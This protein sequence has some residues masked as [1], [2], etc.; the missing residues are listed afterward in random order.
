MLLLSARDEPTIRHIID[1]RLTSLSNVA[2]LE[3][4]I[5]QALGCVKIAILLDVD[6][7]RLVLDSYFELPLYFERTA[8]LNEIDEIAEGIKLARLETL[9]CSD[10]RPEPL[11]RQLPGSGIRG[12]WGQT[13]VHV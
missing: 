12:R 10:V 9:V 2:I 5:K 4:K 11:T 8:L 13:R 6:H 7:L 3:I 1:S